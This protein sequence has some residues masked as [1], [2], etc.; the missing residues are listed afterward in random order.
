MQYYVKTVGSVSNAQ[1]LPQL[2]T[3][4]NRRCGKSAVV[5]W[6]NAGTGIAGFIMKM[7][8]ESHFKSA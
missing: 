1:G 8:D 6:N 2:H 4:G 7:F 5:I 3:R